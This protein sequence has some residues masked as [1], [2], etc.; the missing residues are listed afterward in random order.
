MDDKTTETINTESSQNAFY[1]LKEWHTVEAAASYMAL[2]RIVKGEEWRE[3]ENI[4]AAYRELYDEACKVEEALHAPIILGDMLE[5]I[6]N[7]PYIEEE[8]DKYPDVSP[9]RI[10]DALT[11]IYDLDTDSYKTFNE[12]C[13]GFYTE[14]GAWTV[15]N[16]T[17]TDLESYAGYKYPEKEEKAKTAHEIYMI[18]KNAVI[19]EVDKFGLLPR[20][21]PDEE[22]ESDY[23]YFYPV[24]FNKPDSP[25]GRLEVKVEGIK[26]WLKNNDIYDKY[27][28]QTDSAKPKADPEVNPMPETAASSV[29]NN[30]TSVIN[31]VADL[32]KIPVSPKMAAAIKVLQALHS[33][34]KNFRKKEATKNRI[35]KWLEARY[36]ELGLV[37]SDGTMSVKAITEVVDVVNWNTT[38]GA[39]KQD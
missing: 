9:H 35:R 28:N 6:K 15:C 4:Q 2:G 31:N 24:S 12:I 38:G 10:L 8:M 21:T 27:Y 1:K 16:P 26:A 23:F 13:A 7:N 22:T 33:E 34:D 18:I 19:A 20:F 37:K 39:T 17:M 14:Y 25:K 3:N 11:R 5:W 30:P 36:K 29:A 32:G